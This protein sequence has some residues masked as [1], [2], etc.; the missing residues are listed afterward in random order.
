MY[1]NNANSI[2]DV[3]SFGIDPMIE[4]L[5]AFE[6]DLKNYETELGQPASTFYSQ[7]KALALRCRERLEVI[8]RETIKKRHRCQASSDR[9]NGSG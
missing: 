9:P 2:E 4:L 7:A 8:D 6:N 1:L 3:V 5:Y